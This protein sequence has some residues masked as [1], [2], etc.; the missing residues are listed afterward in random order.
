MIGA[1]LLY[2]DEVVEV[3]IQ[4][5]NVFFKTTSSNKYATIDGIKLDYSSTIREFPDLEVN[6]DWKGIAIERFKQKIKSYPDEMSRITYIIE[7]LK[8]HGYKPK[9]I[10][11]QGFRPEEYDG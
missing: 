4:G 7:D 9:Y 8:K 5:S 3:R 11:R 2:F 10:Q 1:I 6:P